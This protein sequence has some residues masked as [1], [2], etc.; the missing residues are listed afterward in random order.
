MILGTG[1]GATSVLKTIDASK[2]EVTVVSPRNYFLMT[3]LLPGVTV[4]TVEGR[5]IVE[6]VRRLLPGDGRFYEAT[7]VDVDPVAKTVTCVDRSPLTADFPNEPFLLPYDR[8]VLSVGAPFNTFR[9]PGVDKHTIMVKEVEDALAVRSRLMDMLETASLPGVHPET[10]RR[11]CSVVVVGGGPYGVNIAAEISDF[12]R[13]DAPR[14]YPDLRG[15]PS[16]TILSSQDHILS[17]YD[18]RIS[19]FA[20][21]K[22][23]RDDLRVLKGRYVREVFPTEL[24]V[25][26]RRTG[27][28][29]RVP[30]GLC[31]WAT[32]LGVNPLVRA[33]QTR[34]GHKKTRSLSVDSFLRV[35]DAE[36]VYALGDCSDVKEGKRLS[37]ADTARALFARADVD[38]DGS[39]DEEELRVLLVHL[40]A[41]HPHVGLFLGRKGLTVRGLMRAAAKA[42]KKKAVDAARAAAT[43]RGYDH[44]EEDHAAM[45]M[46]ERN[47]DVDLDVELDLDVAEVA[48]SNPDGDENHHPD[49]DDD[50]AN[51]VRLTYEE[52]RDALAGVDA[53]ARGH[54]A[55]AQVAAQQGAYL[56]RALNQNHGHPAGSG[57]D[58]MGYSGV[59][60]ILDGWKYRHMGQFAQL[61]GGH[62]AADLPGDVVWSGMSTMLLWYGAY[63][64]EQISWRNR[65]LVLW[66][67]GRRAVFGRDNSRI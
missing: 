15:V 12:L 58:G 28:T 30:F 6:N 44:P 21:E 47:D 20:E 40:Q 57:G 43:A 8:L 59:G 13:Q 41:T 63:F 27:E 60:P 32:G 22:F 11:M 29:S 2:Y 39:V 17:V 3:A 51:E 50:D 14:L 7:A 31:V 19:R 66:D 61:G 23:A 34:L 18:E 9:A 52:F 54:P 33:L 48:G 5:S 24:C 56:A 1:W 37:C 16:V 25:A 62:A 53:K 46:A 36:G 64:S 42:R 55:T 49:D 38:R 65:W 67:W 4:G 10:R 35:M 26:E 45:E